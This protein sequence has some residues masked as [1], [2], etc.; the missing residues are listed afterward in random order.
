MTT[1]IETPRFPDNIAFWAQGGAGYATSVVLINSG[2][3][4]RNVN[5]AQ[6]R[7]RWDIANTLRS[8]SDVQATIAFFRSM[9]GRAYGFR[10]KD[11]NDYQDNGN[12]GFVA[13]ASSLLLQSVKNY[14]AGA[15]SEARVISK[16]VVGTYAMYHLGVLMTVGSSAGQYTIDTTTGIATLGSGTSDTTPANYSWT[17]EFDV[18]CRF[19]TDDM[20]GMREGD[21]SGSPSGLYRWEPIPIVEIRV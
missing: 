13:G 4:Q 15:L 12:G 1:F 10:F 8:M 5:W 6:S 14:A 21:S 3:E 11:F 20:K 9:K 7:A 2:F 19:D 16:P 18:P 17:G